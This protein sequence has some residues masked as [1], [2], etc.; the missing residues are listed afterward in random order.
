[1]AIRD[2]SLDNNGV[3]YPTVVADTILRNFKFAT[4]VNKIST[5]AD[6]KRIFT[7][8][9]N[10]LAMV[11][12]GTFLTKA[13]TDFLLKEISTNY[14]QWQEGAKTKAVALKNIKTVVHSVVAA[15]VSKIAFR[16]VGGIKSSI[17]PAGETPGQRPNCKCGSRF[18]GKLT[19]NGKKIYQWLPSRASPANISLEHQQFYYREFT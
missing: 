19:T 11:G 12:S 8:I 14:Q 6:L 15:D 13:Q 5:E 18:T 4:S 9:T 7:T 17:Y 16:G 2:I 10:Q 3:L 1:M